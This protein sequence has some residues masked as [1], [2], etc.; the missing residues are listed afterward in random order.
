[1]AQQGQAILAALPDSHPGSA[2]W[3]GNGR[4]LRS[5]DSRTALF[6]EPMWVLS[7]P[8]LGPGNSAFVAPAEE[9]PREAG[10][11]TASPV[12]WVF[13]LHVLGQHL[14]RCQ[15]PF[16]ALGQHLQCCQLAMA[17]NTA[18]EHSG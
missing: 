14:Q 2:S 6:W 3:Q 7:L 8:P 1:M 5:T 9:I 10:A 17:V 11:A 18:R 15:F 16:H 4:A 12:G 13:P